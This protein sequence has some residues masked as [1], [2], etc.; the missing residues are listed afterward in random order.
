MAHFS[1]RTPAPVVTGGYRFFRPFVREDFVRQCAYCLLP[2]ILA[3]GRENFELDHFRPRSRFPHLLNDF[4][5]IYYACHPC[6]HTKRA[7][8]P[9]PELEAL[10]VSLVDLCKDE[11]AAHFRV[12][13][14]GNFEG[15]T[16]H[17]RYTIELLRLNRTDLVIVRKLLTKLGFPVH[18]RQLGEEQLNKL[19]VDGGL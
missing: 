11:F 14:D 9:S 7:G 16:E 5:N 15:V 1:R 4:Y 10:G 3:A 17:G 18:E 13:T 8:W 2:E 12:T 19:L 6:N